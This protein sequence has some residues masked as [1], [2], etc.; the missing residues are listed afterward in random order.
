MKPSFGCRAIPVLQRTGT[1]SV[2]NDY[3]LRRKLKEITDKYRG[4]TVGK[5]I[6]LIMELSKQHPHSIT[7]RREAIPSDRSTFAF[8]C[9][10]YAFDMLDSSEVETIRH[11]Y[12]FTLNIFPGSGFVDFLLNTAVMQERRENAKDGDV[13]LYRDSAKITHAGKIISGRIESKWAGGHL[14]EHDILE[15]PIDYGDE[16]KFVTGIKRNL[17]ISSFFEYAKLKGADESLCKFRN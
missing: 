13:I 6:K 17:C 14:W 3:E 12:P 7:L 2:R 16:L 5:Q 15:V 4:D 11:R 1:V 9:F 10:M 8:N